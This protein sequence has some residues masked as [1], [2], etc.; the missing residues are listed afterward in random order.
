MEIQCKSYLQNHFISTPPPT[1]AH[2]HKMNVYHKK[3]GLLHSCHVNFIIEKNSDTTCFFSYWTKIQRRTLSVCIWPVQVTLVHFYV[4]NRKGWSN[5][6][7]VAYSTSPL[8][9]CKCIVFHGAQGIKIINLGF[10]FGIWPE[11]LTSQLEENAIC[12]CEFQHTMFRSF[13][14]SFF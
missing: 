12:L 3:V 7:C 2:T 9:I 10:L 13:Y 4:R 5:F 6:L 14:V 11:I 8:N 1:H